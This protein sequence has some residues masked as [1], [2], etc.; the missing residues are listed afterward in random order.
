MRLQLKI[1]DN[2]SFNGTFVHRLKKVRV[3]YV[4]LTIKIMHKITRFW[5]I[6]NKKKD[7]QRFKIR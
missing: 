1:Y 4:S 7:Q 5:K 3:S 6:A 2:V